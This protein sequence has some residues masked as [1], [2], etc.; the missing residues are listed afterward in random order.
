M[1][2]SVLDRCL[3]HRTRIAVRAITRAY[4]EALRPA[5]LRA[6]QLA[7]L[8][9]VG[10]RGALSITSL[11]D[12]LGMDRTTLTRNLRPLQDRGYV[13]I[14]PE[15]RYRSR[16]LQLTPSGADALRRA[17]PLWEV[18]QRSM[19]RQLSD[20]RWAAVQEAV[21]VLITSLQ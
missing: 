3:C 10:A 20:G 18:A 17:L 7:V 21:R 6:T 15:G 5:G 14:T 11:A 2:Q 16:M 9:A 12:S 19:Q 1:A 8:A 13:F 4:D